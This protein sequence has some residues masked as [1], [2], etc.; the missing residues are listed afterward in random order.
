MWSSGPI[1]AS[2]A[3]PRSVS[4]ERV[5]D[6]VGAGKLAR[7]RRLVAPLHDGVGADQHERAL[8]EAARMQDA[9][10]LAHGALGL[11]VRELLDLDVQ[12]VLERR[13]RVVRVAGDA[14][15]RGAALGEVL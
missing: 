1:G 8:R 14:V 5:E 15:E 10:G 7:R 11:E 6:Q 9:E 2:G 3:E 4:G 13:L 12:G